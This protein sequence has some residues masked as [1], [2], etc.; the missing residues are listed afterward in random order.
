M[1]FRSTGAYCPQSRQPELKHAAVRVEPAQLPWQLV[2]AVIAHSQVHR[3][4][5]WKV[6]ISLVVIP[7]CCVCGVYAMLAASF[8]SKFAH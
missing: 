8:A 6:V 3:I 5:W 2:A 4:A 7:C 1:L